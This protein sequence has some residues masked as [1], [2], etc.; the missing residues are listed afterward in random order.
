MRESEG[1][2]DQKQEVE[3]MPAYVS[4]YNKETGAQEDFFTCNMDEAESKARAYISRYTGL[5]YKI[6]KIV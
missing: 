3:D 2:R 1:N 4:I 5:G 6:T